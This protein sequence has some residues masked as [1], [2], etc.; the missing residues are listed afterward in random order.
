M[1]TLPE[2]TVTALYKQIEGE[3][4]RKIEGAVWPVGSMLPSRRDLARQYGVST[5]TVERAIDGLV[6]EGLL[7]ADDRRGTFVAAAVSTPQQT[8]APRA[9]STIG[10]VASLY[11]MRHDHLELNNYWVRQL[12]HCIEHS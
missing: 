9:T 1:S 12:V 8:P 5:L 10:I 7:R 4:R 2:P 6:R 3:L 11:L